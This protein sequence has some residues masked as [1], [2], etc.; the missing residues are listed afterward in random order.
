MKKRMTT[1]LVWLGVSFLLL[2]AG[3]GGAHA[4][5]GPIDYSVADVI[6][7]DGSINVLADPNNA[8]A[9]C[10]GGVRTIDYRYSK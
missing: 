4:P 6:C 10:P 2:G 9:L 5:A 8:D 1:P 7:T 3:C